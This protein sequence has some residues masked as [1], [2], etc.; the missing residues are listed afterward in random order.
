MKDA[1]KRSEL[2][3]TDIME[4][5]KLIADLFQDPIAQTDVNGIFQNVNPSF[6]PVLGYSR[7]ELVGKS[8]FDLIHPDDVAEVLQA[9]KKSMESKTADR[10][11]YRYRHAD[12]H[13]IWLETSVQ[14][15]L[16]NHGNILATVFSG[17]DI[18]A[19][20]RVEEERN[21]I[22]ELSLDM[23]CVASLEG[24]FIELNPAW[25]KTVGWSPE[26][27]KAK[28]YLEFVH[29]EDRENTL[30]LAKASLDSAPA[31]KF[32]NRYQCKNGSYRWLSWITSPH[33]EPDL[34]YC[35]VR[36]VTE[37]YEAAKALQ[38]AHDK[39][40]IKVKERTAELSRANEELRSEIAERKSAVEEVRANRDELD[41]L[42]TFSTEMR[43]AKK[44]EELFAYILRE[45]CR[46][47]QSDSGIVTLLSPDKT[48]Y[49]IASGT[50]YFAES[51]GLSF[52]VEQGL[53]GIVLQTKEPFTSENFSVDPQALLLK[54][55][56]K[57]GPVALVPLQS[58]EALVGVLA[59]ARSQESTNLPFTPAEV[60]TL[61]AL[62][63]IAG[64]ALRRQFLFES[65]QKRLDQI[66]TLRNIDMAITGSLD[67]RVTFNVILDEITGLLKTDAAAII[68]LE[69]HTGNIKY[70]AWS[71]F[72]HS[73]P[74][75]LNLRLGEGFAGRV[76]MS[77][78][79]I[80]VPDL[81]DVEVDKYQESLFDREGF[82]AY[83]GIPLIAKDH[84]QGVLEIYHREIFH[85]DGEWLKFLEALASQ[86]AIAIDN[87]ELFHNMERTNFELIQAYD[88][89]IEGWAHAL[90]LKDEETEEHSRRV[91]EMT[92]TIARIMN[93]KDEDLAHVRRGALLHDIGKMGIPDSILLKPG[94]LTDEEWVV[95]RK[96]SVYAYEMLSC[97]EYLRPALD[98]PYCHHEKWDGTGY[99]RG[100]KGKAIPLAARIFAVVDVYDALT[101]DR[102]YRKA[103]LEDDALAYIKSESGTHFDPKVVEV[104]L[105]YSQKEV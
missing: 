2:S 52:P 39:L 48:R 88:A 65:A 40:E 41:T 76:A 90:E 13:Y 25:E 79:A 75:E 68:R 15:L 50:G 95:M 19:R 66:Q 47:L 22:F 46:L 31:I 54:N 26:E 17:H 96:H 104:F 98:I 99:P 9:F 45:A 32:T 5:L 35:V 89:T 21:R 43:T 51:S 10:I 57:L 27:L 1:E 63:E 14:A 81:K 33:S 36:D 77:R 60:Q 34:I 8:A 64:N 12:G 23:I 71:G 44:T 72:N 67:L 24:Y 62:G 100:L 56:D 49:T 101:S 82:M 61:A 59:I 53:S 6:Q 4:S 91:V 29:P 80:H 3:G 86:A 20:K 92:L 97:I 87:A 105:R 7:K 37:Q 70:E 103:W 18:T 30:N 38:E 11:E 84:V 16:D 93:I 74:A 73:N 85:S 55:K 58:E 28:P 69:P 94:K 102:P 83:Y 78:K 42:Y